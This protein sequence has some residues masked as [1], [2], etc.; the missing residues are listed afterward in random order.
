MPETSTPSAASTL[1]VPSESSAAQQEHN[2]DNSIKEMKS[3]KSAH[4]RPREETAS[5]AANAETSAKR[6]KLTAEGIFAKLQQAHS[7]GKSTAGIF[8]KLKNALNDETKLAGMKTDRDNA[9]NGIQLWEAELERLEQERKKRVFGN[10]SK[11][12]SGGKT[13]DSREGDLGVAK[14]AGWQELLN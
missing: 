13:N 10:A 6:V 7:A 5:E 8:D 2:P 4:K 12:K 9:A 14:D 1:P 11:A 3:P